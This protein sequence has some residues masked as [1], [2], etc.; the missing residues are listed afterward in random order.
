MLGFVLKRDRKEE[1]LSEKYFLQLCEELCTLHTANRRSTI[2]LTKNDLEQFETKLSKCKDL[3]RE[4]IP[5]TL[6]RIAKKNKCAP[7][8]P[9]T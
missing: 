5:E 7:N 8:A 3:V 2:D 9:Q 6:A 1:T 4:I